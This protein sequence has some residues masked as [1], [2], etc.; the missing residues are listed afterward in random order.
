[1]KKVEIPIEKHRYKKRVKK[2]M[3]KQK[4]KDTKI[5]IIHM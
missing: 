2:E 5:K 1:M 4:E 3:E